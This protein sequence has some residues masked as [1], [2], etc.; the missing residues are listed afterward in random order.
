VPLNAIST[1]REAV[2]GRWA[3]LSPFMKR[4]ILHTNYRSA[5]PSSLLAPSEI[6]CLSAGERFG[7]IID[8]PNVRTYT[9]DVKR[10]SGDS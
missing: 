7:S 5:R 9:H 3:A 6:E 10:E 1:S 2:P 4:S 8:T